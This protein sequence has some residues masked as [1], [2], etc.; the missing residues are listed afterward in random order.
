MEKIQLF[1]SFWT[2]VKVTCLT[3]CWL[4][5][6]FHFEV[7]IC[8]N[9]MTKCEHLH[10]CSKK[11]FTLS[12]RFLGRISEVFFPVLEILF[13]TL[14]RCLYNVNS[15]L[16]HQKCNQTLQ[17]SQIKIRFTFKTKCISFSLFQFARRIKFVKYY[18]HKVPQ[19]FTQ[20]GIELA[21]E[22]L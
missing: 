19:P 13:V 11:F 2:Y 8:P 21:L 12:W 7:K 17:H 1:N 14:K 10:V 4:Q 22:V 9:S 18:N 20:T 6:S 16:R 5:N 3:D 15:F